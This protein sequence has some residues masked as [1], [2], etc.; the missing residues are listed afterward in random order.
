LLQAADMAL[1]KA[2]Q[3]GRN[4]VETGLLLTADQTIRTSI[5]S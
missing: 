1:Y 5:L 4:R 3:K 2:K